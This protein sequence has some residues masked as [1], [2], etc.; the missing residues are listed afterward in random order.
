M[1]LPESVIVA[2]L[3]FGL[4]HAGAETDSSSTGAD[5]SKAA[6]TVKAPAAAK[7]AEQVMV[8][9]PPTSWSKIKDLFM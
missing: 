7:Q 5:S 1:K 3:S 2:L 6:A 9:Q 4:L 8:P